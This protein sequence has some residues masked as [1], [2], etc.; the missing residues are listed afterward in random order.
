MTTDWKLILD[1]AWPLAKGLVALIVATGL[2]GLALQFWYSRRE[3]RSAYHKLLEVAH[4]EAYINRLNIARISSH[5]SSGGITHVAFSITA[6]RDV[7]S[8]PL[9]PPELSTTLFIYVN[10]LDVL[11]RTL[12]YW[13]SPARLEN[14]SLDAAVNREQQKTIPMLKNETPVV[15]QAVVALEQEM[16]R[17]SVRRRIRSI[18]VVNGAIEIEFGP[19]ESEL[20]E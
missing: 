4:T 16:E 2:V 5:L 18:Q 3:Q 14:P 12:A 11:N 15:E 9:A 19:Y 6:A 1:R 13:T 8:H 17:C 7:I 20:K 10:S